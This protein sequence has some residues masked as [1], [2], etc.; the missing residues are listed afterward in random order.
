LLKRDATNSDTVATAQRVA[1]QSPY[2]T[3]GVSPVIG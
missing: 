1:H 3:R 2:R